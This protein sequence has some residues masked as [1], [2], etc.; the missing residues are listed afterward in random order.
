MTNPALPRGIRNNN[1][2]NIRK[3]ATAWQGE[4]DGADGAFETF[5]D[6]ED[7]L[8][9]LARLLLRYA[10]YGLDTVR[11]VLTRYAPACEND[12]DGYVA[13]VAARLGVAPDEPIRVGDHLEPLMRAIVDHENGAGWAEHYPSALYAA[14]MARARRRA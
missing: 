2:G 5:R 12:T 4:V 7:G 1:P 10:D 8:R 3:T 9:A 11:A 6:P 14:A 13:H